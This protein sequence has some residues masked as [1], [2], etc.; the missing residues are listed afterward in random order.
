MG[1]RKEFIWLY[2]SIG[3]F[4]FMASSFLLMPIDFRTTK[5]QFMS[6]CVGIMFWIFMILGI[7]SQIILA[8]QR[9]NWFIKNRIRRFRTKSKLGVIAFMQNLPATIADITLVVSIIALIV[10]IVLTNAMG[11]ACYIFMALLV[12]SFCMHCIL[13]GKIYYYLTNQSTIL[14]SAQPKQSEEKEKE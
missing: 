12:F 14:R 2:I 3:S 5:L 10:S 7:V 9:K 6:Y 8:K 13:N 4:F 11:Y 1:S